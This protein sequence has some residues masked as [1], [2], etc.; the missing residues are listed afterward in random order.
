MAFLIFNI[1]ILIIF[2]PI[3]FKFLNETLNQT[4]TTTGT[5][6]ETF[7][8]THSPNETFTTTAT[9]IGTPDETTTTATTTGTHNETSTTTTTTTTDTTNETT[10][11]FQNINDG[12]IFLPRTS[13]ALYY[14]K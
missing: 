8:T 10:T 13:C 1:L 11:H 5:P 3:I 14:L 2:S 7:T 9:T 4:S 12:K 6:N